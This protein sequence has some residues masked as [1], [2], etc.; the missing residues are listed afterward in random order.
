MLN[1]GTG[2]RSNLI[3]PFIQEAQS[4]QTDLC[5][6]P[7]FRTNIWTATLLSLQQYI[8]Q[9]KVPFFLLWCNVCWHILVG[10]NI[11]HSGF[12]F[13]ASKAIRVIAGEKGLR[14]LNS[15]KT[16]SVVGPKRSNPS[17][18]TYRCEIDV[19]IANKCCT[20][21]VYF[22]CHSGVHGKIPVMP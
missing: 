16:H 12:E 3:L 13:K 10:W 22:R 11:Y 21:T 5:E 14:K 19:A 7:S 1:E 15:D 17:A 9:L 8:K 4:V 20:C 6:K 18:R 2:S